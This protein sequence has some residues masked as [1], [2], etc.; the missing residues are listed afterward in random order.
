MPELSAPPRE[1]L[2][3]LYQAALDFNSTLDLDEL[4]PRVFDRVLDVLDAEAGSIWL[5]KDDVVVCRL[6]R[7]PAS[8]GLEGLELPVGVGIVGDVARRG[9]PEIVVDAREDPRFVRQVDDATG[10]VTRSMI[11]APMEARSEVLGVLQ[12]LN[13]RSGTRRFDESDLALLSG[14]A[15]TAGIALRNAQLHA[16]EKRARDLKALLGVS[17]EI[18]STMDVDRLLLS[19]VN[20]GS[21]ALAYDRAAIALDEGGRPLL[22]AI[23][24]EEAVDPRLEANRQLERLILWLL[25][26]DEVVYVPDVAGEDE[27]A[28]KLR[29]AFGGYL[30]SAGIRSLCLVP[31]KDDEGRLGALYMEAAAPAFLGEAGTEAAELLANQAS[32]ALRNAELYSQVPFVGI[33][34]RTAAWRRRTASAPRSRLLKRLAVPAAI[35]L[36]LIAIPWG[37]RVK[38]REAR[39]LPGM[40]TPIRATVG[41]LIT[42]VR[43]EEGAPV[44]PGEVLAVLRDDEIRFAIQE[45][46]A[47]LAVAERE[48]AAARARNDQSGADVARVEARQLAARLALL[49]E[50]LER[51]RLRALSAGVV[52]T[53]RPRERLGEWL[54]AGE[55]F[56]V[57]GRPDRLEVE[58][59]V[60]QQDIGRVRT[61]QPMR[62]RV[63]ARPEYTFVGRVTSVA[64]HAD[65]LAVPDEPTFAVRGELANERGLLRPGMEAKT[66]IVGPLRPIGYFLVR[67]FVRWIQLRFWR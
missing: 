34:E 64:A 50:Q 28:A 57:L 3:L 41:G 43:I 42:E 63:P 61:G 14:L 4:L 51:T 33:L 40:R 49:R 36:A 48:G 26:R 31:L 7:G 38:A 18:T 56:V 37:E 45:A 58:A 27:P 65:S 25:E 5:R 39:L 15:L 55:T 53:P 24:G 12:V 2:D 52:L 32:V 62:V 8:E 54:A 20:L 19:I 23:S 60:A 29:A 44:E 30:E 16:V 66:K 67:P 46:E 35:I 17:R 13:K 21:Q 1:H 9:E 6:A 47:A 22:R 59:L 10:F 11:A